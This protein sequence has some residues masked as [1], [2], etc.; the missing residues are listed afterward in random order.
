MGRFGDS[1]RAHRRRLGLTQEDLAGRASVGLRT[2]RDIETDR[3]TRPRLGTVRLLADAF[4]LQGADRDRF[5]ESAQPES[6]EEDA[7][8][9]PDPDPMPPRPTPA[10]LPADVAGFTGREDVLFQLSSPGAAGLTVITGMAGVGKTAVAVHWAHRVSDEFPDGRL[11]VNLRGFDRDDEVVDPAD[12]VR[13]FLDALGVEPRHIPPGQDAQAALYRSLSAHRRLLV[14]LD[15]AR[16]ADQVRPLLAAGPGV[17]TVI[18]SRNR[19][20]ALVAELGAQPIALGLPDQAE[21]VELLSRRISGQSHDA[22]AAAVIVAACGRLPLALALVAARV[23][24]TGFAPAAVAAELHRPGLAALDEMRVVFSWSYRALSPPAARLFRL[25]GLVTGADIATAAVAALAGAA[26]VDVRRTLRELTDASL[27]AE[28]APARYQLHDLLRVYAGEL[29]REAETEGDRRAALTRLLDHYTHRAYQ[30]ELVLNP[31]RAPI[32]AGFAGGTRSDEVKESLDMKAALQWLGTE[33]AVLLSALRQARDEGLDRHAWQLGWALDTFLYEHRRWQ[34][35]G[36]AWAVALTAATTLAD[37]PAAAH[38]HRFLGAVAGRLERFGEA[39]DH[40]E[41]SAELCRAA[42]DRAGEAETHFVL[43]YVC[44]LQADTDSALDHAER[45]LALWA[46]LDHPAWEGKASNVVGWYYAALGADQ[47][48][49]GFYE[50]ALRLL[51]L[52]EDGP[53][54]VVARVNLGLA[55]HT[56]GRYETAFDHYRHGQRLARALG[57]RV[58]DAQLSTHLGDTYQTIGADEA[59]RESWQHAYGILI[60]LG[61]PQAADV[62][63]RL[64]VVG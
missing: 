54:E 36:A 64:G 27:L 58:M 47:T 13:G 28:H 48:A 26:P 46:E 53:N 4:G 23:R 62:G 15:N 19:L 14:V 22:R 18:T 55:H 16:D 1:V 21:A 2:I 37:R 61:H 45:S 10:Q 50:R 60:D 3:I 24:Q 44:W 20:T 6:T 17:R 49:L 51:Q 5:H 57:D 59:A 63:R 30:A 42:G 34:D 32:P 33:R 12:A 52:A 25:L 35:E 41:K 39:H 11:Y 38:A 8:S 31:T 9:D 56:L 40:M 43:S 7:A 29:A